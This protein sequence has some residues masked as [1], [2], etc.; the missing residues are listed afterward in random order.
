VI[1]DYRTRP[2]ASPLSDD[3]RRLIDEAVTAG[4]VTRCPTGAMATAVEYQWIP[5]KSLREHSVGQLVQV[6]GPGRS[7]KAQREARVSKRIAQMQD[8][9][10]K[11]RN[12]MV[13]LLLAGARRQEIAE[14]FSVDE[15]TVRCDVRDLKADGRLPPDFR[16]PGR[17][18]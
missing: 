14:R 2:P 12:A 11:R 13:P 18:G 17:W 5:A 10:E 16:F 6:G 3:E 4:R 15:R 7:W 1:L 8:A 9:K